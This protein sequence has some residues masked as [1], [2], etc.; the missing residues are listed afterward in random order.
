MR[1][2]RYL[3]KSIYRK[4]VLSF[5]L[6][7][8]LPLL[9]LSV[10]S[11]SGYVKSF[12]NKTANYNFELMKLITDKM[13]NYLIQIEQLSFTVYQDNIQQ[14]LN[15]SSVN[16]SVQMIKD[17]MIIEQIF[18]RQKDFYNFKGIINS[19]TLLNI[20]GSVRFDSTGTID[21]DFDFSKS[22]WFEKVLSNENTGLI[23]GPH[24]QPYQ[25]R[26]S[27]AAESTEEPLAQYNLSYIRKIGSIDMP[28][29]ILGIIIIDFGLSEFEKLIQPLIMGRSGEITILDAEKTVIFDSNPQKIGKKNDKVYL[30]ESDRK[31]GYTSENINGK[32]I[33][34]SFYRFSFTGWEIYC[35]NDI[36]EMVS[37][38]DEILYVTILLVIISFIAAVFISILLSFGLLKPIKNLQLMMKKVR[39]GDL[40]VQAPL[41]SQ[42]EI[43]ELCFG[44]NEMLQKIRYLV[45]EVYKTQIHEREAQLNA[46]QAQINPHFLYNTLE[47]ISSIAQVEEV[48]IISKIARAM[49]NMFRYSTRIGGAVVPISE[50]IRHIDNYVSILE[51]RFENK[52]EFII[53][54]P[55]N[56]MDYGIIKLVLQPIVENAVFHGI[57]MKTGKGLLKISAKKIEEDIEI[58][59]SDNGIGMTEAKIIELNNMLNTSENQFNIEFKNGRVGI[60]NVHE[61]IKLYF[62]EKYGLKIETAEETGTIVR[63][64][65]P[66]I[67]MNG[68]H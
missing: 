28:G 23:I 59:V 5:I 36:K 21:E 4:F 38:T 53:D 11:Y 31:M 41:L 37:D 29:K 48:D 20:D 45:E 10:L 55:E 18:Q 2:I 42:D 14:I 52:F 65:I 49:S 58:T 47:T 12:E 44:F 63:I 66:A 32:Q 43:G 22:S 27:L 60:R 6:V 68:G 25:K 13:E 15:K 46:L 8:L 54:V 3:R 34:V 7:S 19:I 62:G 17:T 40:T 24:M 51:V 33:M 61:R 57:E 1:I 39:D 26:F 67:P 16:D 64:L 9:F 50:E 30:T 56:L 35:L